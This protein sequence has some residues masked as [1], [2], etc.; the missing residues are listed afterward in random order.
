MDNKAL[1]N[2]TYGLFLIGVEAGG[3]K[4]ACITNTA[5]QVASNPTRISLACINGN[6]T[7]ELIKESGAFSVSILDET[8][9]FEF[10][11]NFGQQHGRAID[12]FAGYTPEADSNGMPYLKD[13]ACAVLSAK[14]VSATDLGSH[15]L[16]IAEVTDAVRLSDKAPV[17]YNDYQTRIKPKPEE[18]KADKKIVAWKCKICGYVY[19]GIELPADFICPICGHPAS[20]FEPVYE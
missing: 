16:F 5:I 10:F 1:Y 20:D 13:H 6:Y 2:L 19:K 3:R 14:V 8:T 18:P 7:P 11:R 17:T 4:N 12:K 15:T 9:P